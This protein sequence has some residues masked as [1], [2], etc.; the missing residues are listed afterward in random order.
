[1][2]ASVF[3]AACVAVPAL[4]AGGTMAQSFGTVPPGQILIV[5]PGQPPRTVAATNPE[6]SGIERIFAAQNAMMAQEIAQIDQFFS[7]RAGMMADWPMPLPPRPT[8]PRTL[9]IAGGQNGVSVC[10]E[11][12]S[13][14]YDGRGGK[15]IV[16]VSRSGNGCGP[17]HPA[18][19]VPAV[20]A[21]RPTPPRGPRI[22]EVADPPIAA[23]SAAR[24]PT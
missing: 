11:S 6:A 9:E 19:S 8:F 21:P 7:A 5:T 14:I 22:L 2:L 15:P 23:P 1:M 4:A 3:R 20:T 16:K 18:G 13:I 12:M 24:H 17:E 10:Q